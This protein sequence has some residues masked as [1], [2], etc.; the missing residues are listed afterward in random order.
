MPFH[1]RSLLGHTTLVQAQ[2]AFAGIRQHRFTIDTRRI[3]VMQEKV[4]QQFQRTCLELN[5]FEI[6]KPESESNIKEQNPVIT[7]PHQEIRDFFEWSNHRINVNDQ[8]IPI[9]RN[10]D[11]LSDWL[12]HKH[13]II[14]DSH[15]HQ[16]VIPLDSNGNPPLNPENWGYWAACDRQLWH[17]RQLY[18]LAELNRMLREPSK[19]ISPHYETT[20]F[21]HS[22]EPNL[23]AYRAFRSPI[24]VPRQGHIFLAGRIPQLTLRCFIAVCLQ[25]HLSDNEFRYESIILDILR[26]SQDDKTANTNLSQVLYCEYHSF[27]AEDATTRNNLYSEAVRQFKHWISSKNDTGIQWSNLTD[28]MLKTCCLNLPIEI[29]RRNLELEQDSTE[30]HLPDVIWNRLLQVLETRI[31]KGFLTP[32]LKDSTFETILSRLRLSKEEAGKLLLHPKYSENPGPTLR[33]YKDI[34]GHP[35]NKLLQ[36]FPNINPDELLAICSTSLTGRLTFRSKSLAQVRTQEVLMTH[37]DVMMS[38]AYQ[39]VTRGHRLLGFTEDEFVLEVH[40][41]HA[42]EALIE[43]VKALVVATANNILQVVPSVCTLNTAEAW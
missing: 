19:R 26:G 15:L 12:R 21:L 28:M 34:P 8:G 35:L 20:P 39:L 23:Q 6:V 37:D 38:V 32:F 7:F 3:S 13:S 5:R 33:N 1:S 11:K 16:P 31:L 22:C 27:P 36:Y 41:D 18:R 25:R 24:F 43:Q 42:T 14:F 9:S 40:E 2:I 17:W 4:D 10:L 30:L 29:L